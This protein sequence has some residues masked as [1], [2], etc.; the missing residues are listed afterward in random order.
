MTDQKEWN[1]QFI[2]Q[3]F[4]RNIS[5]AITNLAIHPREED[6]IHWN[7]NSTGKF[8]AKALYKAK[9][10]N[11]YRNDLNTRNWSS[12][13]HMEVT[14]AIKIF[15][16]KCAHEILP[17]NAKNASILHYVDL[18]CKIWNSGEETMTHL[19][20]NCPVAVE[21]WHQ[22]LGENL[23]LFDHHTR[24]MDWFNTWFHN[25]RNYV[26]SR[27][28]T[29][30]WGAGGATG[31]ADLAFAWAEDK[32]HM[33]IEI[34]AE[35]TD[36]LKHFNA[37]YIKAIKGRF[38]RNYHREKEL[39]SASSVL[40]INPVTFVLTVEIA[41]VAIATGAAV[42]VVLESAAFAV[43]LELLHLLWY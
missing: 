26:D 37:L 14:P 1:L 35:T 4:S 40:S 15:L 34:H 12:I 8:S 38:S 29:G 13:W 7:L 6:S 23:G 2:Q 20:L 17:T 16:W 9:I 19:F 43:V 5:Q 24:F 32:Q 28:H 25:P 39:L 42:A 31:G 21:V 3:L 11:L 22:M 33:N 27:G 10:E 36:I 30:Q 41:E 18:I